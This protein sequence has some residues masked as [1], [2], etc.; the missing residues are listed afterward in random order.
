MTT[1]YPQP[2]FATRN[3]PVCFCVD[4][5]FAP[6]FSVALQSIL[7]TSS[8]TW[9]YDI[10]ILE[11]DLS[12]ITKA[13]LAHQVTG[14]SNVSLRYFNMASLVQQYEVK[15]WRHQRHMSPAVYYRL[16]ISVIFQQYD[17]VLYL[18]SD[19]L[20]KADLGDLFMT[21]MAG[22]L[23]AAVRNYG[24]RELST[25]FL[26]DHFG[27]TVNTKDYIQSVLGLAEVNDYFNSGVLLMN[28]AEI[29]KRSL[30]EE[31]IKFVPA[32]YCL[33]AHDQN[34]LNAVCKG[35]IL[36]LDEYWNVQLHN[37]FR[38]LRTFMSKDELIGLF[39]VAKILHFSSKDK[40]RMLDPEKGLSSDWWECA[41]KTPF[42]ESLIF[43]RCKAII[44]STVHNKKSIRMAI[45]KKCIKYFC[46]EKKFSKYSQNRCKFFEDSKNIFVKIYYEILG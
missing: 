38:P 37:I 43:E 13:K 3:L 12:E 7:D 41:R 45:E 22:Y 25:G 8:E 17:K 18:D 16:F 46:L 20:T 32:N 42:Y 6:Y 33:F 44:E 24:N 1:Q 29:N 28:I 5:R 4:T 30:F 9:N 27:C 19:I 39:R 26:T 35:F 23:L 2:A 34:I 36:Y 40:S 21:D 11:T 14:R 10:I 31:F 15:S